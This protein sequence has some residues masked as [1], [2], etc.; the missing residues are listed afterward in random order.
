MAIALPFNRFSNYEKSTKSLKS[1]AQVLN[2]SESTYRRNFDFGS[3]RQRIWKWLKE[4]SSICDRL[5][6]YYR[7]PHPQKFVFGDFGYAL[8]HELSDYHNVFSC[9][10]W[11]RF[12][13]FFLLFYLWFQIIF[14]AAPWLEIKNFQSPVDVRTEKFRRGIRI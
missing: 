11:F 5:S 4:K 3:Q 1:R 13:D 7:E 10:D 14:R 8:R 12:K 2:S 6:K 9:T